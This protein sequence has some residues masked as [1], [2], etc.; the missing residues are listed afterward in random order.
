M[1]TPAVQAQ[2]H[3]RHQR[4]S[5]Q[6]FQSYQHSMCY[7]CCA[8]YRSPDGRSAPYFVSQRGSPLQFKR[9]A[10]SNSSAPKSQKKRLLT[11]HEDRK[12]REGPLLQAEQAL[13]KAG[14]SCLV[15]HPY[16]DTTL[17]CLIVYVSH[18]LG[19]HDVCIQ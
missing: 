14:E 3:A 4:S 8:L 17:F 7:C 19:H 16:P 15:Q 10:K 18:H 1:F 13:A 2:G 12:A 5:M 6:Q 11:K 9:M